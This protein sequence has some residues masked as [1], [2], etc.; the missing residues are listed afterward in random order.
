M[1]KSKLNDGMAKKSSLL[2]EVK[3][4][5]ILGPQS[6]SKV[7]GGFKIYIEKRCKDKPYA[8]C[9]RTCGPDPIYSSPTCG[10]G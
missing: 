6:L 3:N 7:T 5:E 9:P 2:D 8:D 1:L 4:L 10:K